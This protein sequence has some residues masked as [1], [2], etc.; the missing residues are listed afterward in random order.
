MQKLFSGI[1]FVFLAV[2]SSLGQP[3]PTDSVPGQLL[4]QARLGAN[5]SVV[6]R[7]LAVHGAAVQKEIP[8]IHVHVLRVPEPA[9]DRVQQALAS[10]GLFTF[11]ERDYLK[12]VVATPNDPDFVSQWHL[13]KIQ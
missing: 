10:S 12:H 4:V 6:A 13:N 11:V 7:T 3:K 1:V 8:Q 2:G 5:P 9:I